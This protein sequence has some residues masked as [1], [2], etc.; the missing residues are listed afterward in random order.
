M[1]YIAH[2]LT[3]LPAVRRWDTPRWMHNMNRVLGKLHVPIRLQRRFDHRE[4]MV[5][6]E[7]IANFELLIH[8]LLDHGVPGA[9]VELGCY[10]G[11]T[12]SV[13]S[14]LLQ[15]LDPG[16]AF[17]VYD[18]FDIELGR[19]RG[20]RALFEANMQAAVVPMPI[21]HAGDVYDLVPRELP[22]RIAFAHI[23]LGTGRTVQ[24][25]L[26]LMHHTLAAVYDRLEPEGILFLMDHH[27]NGKT[28]HGHDSN[29]G[30]RIAADMFFADKP[31][32]IHLLY[33]GACSHAYVRKRQADTG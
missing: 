11:S 29:P 5:S 9:F 23:D 31:E 24:N 26:P 14:C 20:I 30:V 28:I 12:A 10:M 16:R 21:I 8:D 13:I 22:D 15:D 18:S 3:N 25:H 6:L 19:D 4:D 17:H 33:G 27:V 7:Q 32:G 2:T 1:A